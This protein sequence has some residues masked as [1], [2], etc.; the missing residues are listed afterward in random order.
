MS[1]AGLG[2][3]RVVKNCDLGLQYS[4]NGTEVILKRLQRKP[5][6]SNNCNPTLTAPGAIN[7]DQLPHFILVFLPI[8]Q[9]VLQQLYDIRVILHFMYST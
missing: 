3:V 5:R 9:H 4:Q 7:D 2:L 1:L 6:I 8:S